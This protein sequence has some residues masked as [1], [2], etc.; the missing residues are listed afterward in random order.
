MKKSASIIAFTLLSMFPKSAAIADGA[1]FPF[2]L[3]DCS[4]AMTLSAPDDF[5]GG[6]SR[7]ELVD[8]FVPYMFKDAEGVLAM[9]APKRPRLVLVVFQPGG[10]RAG[11]DT[12]TPEQFENIKSQIVARNPSDAVVEANDFLKDQGSSV[13]DYDGFVVS[14]TD[15]S[16]S[17]TLVV[18]GTTT[19]ADFAS[20]LGSKVI[21]SDHCLVGVMLIAPASSISR[22]EFEELVQYLSVQ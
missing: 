11:Q 10:S 20:L 3:P 21:Y 6:T 19:G 2:Q 18:N 1:M 13:N 22:K 7:K 17:V 4:A 16:A 15:N 9:T 8:Q 5:V 14:S 12:I